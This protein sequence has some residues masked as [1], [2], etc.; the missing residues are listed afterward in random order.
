MEK[1][2]DKCARKLYR[3]LNYPIAQY[4]SSQNARFELSSVMI[5]LSA[6][7]FTRYLTGSTFP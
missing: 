7:R 2:C 4:A 1:S 5:H 3:P 6:F